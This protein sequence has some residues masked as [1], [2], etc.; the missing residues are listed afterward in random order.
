MAAAGARRLSL[1]REDNDHHGPRLDRALARYARYAQA[2]PPGWPAAPIA[3]FARFLRTQVR[4]SE[5]PEHGMAY[6]VQRFNELTKQMSA[7]AHLADREHAARTAGR[8]RRR[9]QLQSLVRQASLRFNFRVTQRPPLLI[10]SELLE[11]EH[12]SHQAAGRRLYAQAQQ[13]E[14]L[15]LRDQRLLAGQHPGD[16]DGRYRVAW[17]HAQRW[18]L[19]APRWKG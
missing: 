12:P 13:R 3:G 5:G 1:W 10:A 6:D 14:R 9:Q 11:S 18:G 15:E 2:R 7:Y 4:R 16:S 19:P 17:R 8:A